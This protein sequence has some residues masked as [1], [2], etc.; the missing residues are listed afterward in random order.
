[1]LY[2]VSEA[3]SAMEPAPV[4][5]RRLT[6]RSKGVKVLR[7][8][9][10][11]DRLLGDLESLAR[12]GA[13]GGH[14][15]NRIAYS[16]AD[17]E[18]RRWVETQMTELGLEVRVDQ[19]GNSIGS[20]P[21]RIPK[22][23]PI[24]IGSHTDTVPEGGRFDGALGVAAA[25]SCVRALHDSELRLRHSVE[26]IDFAAEEATM[27]GT[28]GSRAMAGILD[29]SILHAPAWDGR[30]VSDHIRAA[31]L[32]PDALSEAELAEG[33]L[34]C[35]LEL[36]V[37]QGGTLEKAG[38]PLGVVEGIVGIRRY[39]VR[40]EGLANHAGTTPMSERQDALVLAA[41][42][43]LAV[44]DIAVAH[45]IVGTVGKLDLRPGTPSAI[46][47][48]AELSVEIRGLDEHRLDEAETALSESATA[49]GGT[50]SPL[51]VK[52]PVAS[53]P[54][55]IETL[56]AVCE[57]RG[58]AH[59]RMPSGAGHDAMC[60]AHIAPVAMLFVPSR[61]GISHSPDEY[62]ATEHCVLGTQVLLEAL[63]KV[64]VALDAQ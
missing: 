58:A 63:L 46:P 20:Y 51:S 36:H 44:R 60:M 49:R 7:P 16:P 5:H 24:A 15:V 8:T 30:E 47:G 33:S 64:D 9:V 52:P 59:R 27:G 42:Y 35:F 43:I 1:M 26:V 54:R 38:V 40:F 32:N 37:E 31:G 34:A 13:S 48:L 10:D 25:L 53:D 3:P 50:L 2:S 23:P 17:L 55:L 19:A 14:A 39:T 61:G 6:P 12:F 22:L 62:T 41:P 56:V 4:T 28:I 45:E 57:E 11:G 21:G 29:L 18:A